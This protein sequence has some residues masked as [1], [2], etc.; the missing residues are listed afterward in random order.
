MP[1][2][3]RAGTRLSDQT[4]SALDGNTTLVFAYGSNMLTRRIRS[5][6]PSAF[7][8]APGEIRGYRMAFHKRGMDG[9]GKAN[10]RR[11]G[12]AGDRVHGVLFGVNSRELP[13]LDALEIG[14]R[15]EDLHVITHWGHTVQ[16]ACYQA[17]EGFIQPGLRP[18]DWY[19]DL[20]LAGAREHRLPEHH[21]LWIEVQE[22]DR[23]PDDAR[24]NREMSLLL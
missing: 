9:S 20:V 21:V 13:L 6:T 7:S 4:G 14:Y 12:D 19:R 11:T 22:A 23:D 16:A 17:L 15:R 3:G 1:E 18:F 5:R 24:R 2:S 10:I 8:I